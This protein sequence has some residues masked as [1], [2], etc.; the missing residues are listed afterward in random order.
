MLFLAAV[1]GLI[2]WNATVHEDS[3]QVAEYRKYVVSKK[4]ENDISKEE[5]E[6]WENEK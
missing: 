3:H 6:E 1:L 4:A 2:A 5:L